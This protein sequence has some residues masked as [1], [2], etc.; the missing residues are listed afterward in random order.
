ME[1]SLYEKM[2]ET[3]RLEVNK[4][5]LTRIRNP[6]LIKTRKLDLGGDINQSAAAVDVLI[7]YLLREVTL[8]IKMPTNAQRWLVR[9]PR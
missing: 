9:R 6:F 5:I 4:T 1:S 3:V 8:A 2:N 7:N